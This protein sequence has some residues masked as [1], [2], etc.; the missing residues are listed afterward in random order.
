MVRWRDIIDAK[1]EQEYKALWIRLLD[2]YAHQQALVKYLK[3][4]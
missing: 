1:T 3:E 2:D 4:K